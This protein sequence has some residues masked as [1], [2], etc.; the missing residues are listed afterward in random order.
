MRVKA[1]EQTE[2]FTCEQCAKVFPK[3]TDLDLHIKTK[4]FV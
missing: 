4:H 2:Q 1:E 3:Q